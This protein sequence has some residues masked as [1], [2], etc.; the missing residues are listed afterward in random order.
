MKA[1]ASPY[2]I[3]MVYFEAYPIWQIYFYACARNIVSR[4]KVCESLISHRPIP[5]LIALDNFLPCHKD[6]CLS[7][8]FL[9][10]VQ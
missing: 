7:F 1:V 5:D 8:W 6:S 9:Q 10:Y 3:S 2:Q 4:P